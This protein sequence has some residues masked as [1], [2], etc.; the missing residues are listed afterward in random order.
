[1]NQI[2]E[3]VDKALGGVVKD[4]PKLPAGFRKWLADNAWWLTAIGAVLLGLS[5]LSSLT[6]L[7]SPA[8]SVYDSWLRMAGVNTDS[9]R[10]SLI[11]NIVVGAISVVLYAMA[12]SPLKAMRK[13]GWDFLL[14]AMLVSVVGSLVAA[15][16]TGQVSS[17]LTTVIGLA[18]AV[19]ILYGVREYF[20]GKPAKSEAA[21]RA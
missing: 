20:T 14:L 21:D 6:A 16:A 8:T 18:I 19:Y 3:P 15:V 5:V 17:L 13:K 9:L 2:I 7:S 11:I 10:L 12:V 1:M 4:V